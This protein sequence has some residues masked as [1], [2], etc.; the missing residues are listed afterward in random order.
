[1][2]HGNS[3]V[4]KGYAVGKGKQPTVKVKDVELMDWEDVSECRSFGA[5][6]ND[7]FVDIS[8][9][10]D[11]LAEKFWNMAEENNWNC[12][13]LENPDNGHIHSF[14]KKPDKWDSK[15]GKDKNLAVG[16]VADVHSKSTY[17]PLKVNGVKRYPPSFEPSAIDIVPEELFPVN[18]KITLS[19]L[20]EGDGRNDELFK[21]I[22]VLQS[23]L[24]VEKDVIKRIL[25]NINHFMFA[26]SLS[27][28]EMETITRD[29]A[30]TK[31]IF[32]EGKT[33]KHNAFAQYIKNEFNVKRINGQLHV[34]DNG[35]Y[36]AGYNRIE[37]K[38]VEVI[39]SLRKT[40]RTE[41]LNYLEIVTPDEGVEVDAKYIAF[42]NGL[43][44]LETR[45]L[46]DFSPEY[47][48]TN[49]IPF[50]YNP[51]AYS[52]LADKTMNK[53]SCN[54]PEIR[55]LLEECIGYCF[56]KHN[57]LS[58]SFM[59][60]GDGANGKSTYLDMVKYVLG[61][62]NY[63]ALDLNELSE[64]FSTA[65][66]F[67]KLANIG[68]DISDEFLQG[69]TISQFKKIV[70]G[71][72]IKGE[73]KGQDAFF[74]KPSVKLLFSANEIPRMRNKGFAAIKRRMEIIPFNAHFT[75]KD[76]DYD[77]DLIW[78]LRTPE[79]AEYLIQSAIAG[80]HRV[81]ATNTFTKSTK[82]AEEMHNFERDNNPV[83][84]FVEEFGE[85]NIVNNETKKVF[86]QYDIFCYQNGFNKMALQ[87]FSKEVIRLLG[88]ESK[89]VRTAN[90][91]LARVFVKEG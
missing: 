51:N 73:N 80:L 2:W 52:E 83:I 68:D 69:N 65:S 58:K 91:T 6:L 26:D 72:D 63:V 10:S 40:Q 42:R 61:R 32:Y 1:M 54:D 33:F 34:Y 48:V 66:L 76:K 21:Y 23:Q 88:V 77:P 29:E 84:L 46:V 22:L 25:N 75:D 41:T 60:T 28:E 4:F 17:I 14:W 53:L 55:A 85:E 16:L 19:D 86:Q 43:Y 56:Y 9:D 50:D 38:M 20:G 45:Q 57:E 87:T 78:K 70:S 64:R 62:Q 74:F 67:G 18:S 24:T 81:L 36:R 5:I 82:V 8:F 13:I 39:P 11:E 30:F 89:V 79:V 90:K 12:L 37:S 44:S 59:L 3:V 71:N 15:D 47:I 31:P 7:G 35:I 27:V 49:M